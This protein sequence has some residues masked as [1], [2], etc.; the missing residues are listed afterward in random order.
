MDRVQALVSQA[1]NM[2]SLK[3]IIL[4]NDIPQSYKSKGE[5]HLKTY[6]LYTSFEGKSIFTIIYF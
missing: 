3:Y 1:N 5:S 6:S 4:V 2:T